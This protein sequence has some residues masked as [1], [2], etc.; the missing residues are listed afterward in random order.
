MQFNSQPPDDGL[1]R[2]TRVYGLVD[3]LEPAPPAEREQ[4]DIF[5]DCLDAGWADNI[6]LANPRYGF[7]QVSRAQ[8]SIVRFT[9]RYGSDPFGRQAR[10]GRW[11]ELVFAPDGPFEVEQY[12][13]INHEPIKRKVRSVR[14]L[15]T[16][17]SRVL[18]RLTSLDFV[19]DAS[20]KDLSALFVQPM[21]P[22]R[23]LAVY[24][25][26]QG[27][28]NA[29]C[30]IF[31]T[32]LVYFDFGGGTTN[33]LKT[34]PK[35]I[36]FCFGAQPPVVLSHWD[37]DHWASGTRDTN[38]LD[39]KWIA[40]RQRVG[41]NHAKFANDLASRGNL[42]LWPKNLN[43]LPTPFGNIVRCTGTGRND[44]GLA[45]YPRFF[46]A[47]GTQVEAL[48]PGDARYSTIPES[49][50]KAFDAVVATTTAEGCG[51][52]PCRVRMP[53]RLPV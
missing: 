29:I 16:A 51:T 1:Y 6:G 3:Q 4:F 9:S 49:T 8:S 17:K 18:S 13:S 38:S 48:L 24:D 36:R 7:E 46:T 5:F 34:Y 30:T 47:S 26:G 39:V 23:G 33:N 41:L 40:P 14:A 50:A 31:G 20:P 37:W 32:P 11:F 10:E 21:G 35:N 2:V 42:L 25:V 45:F 15:P 43:F 52:K 12:A 22:A 44:S 19:P 28:C 27:N 53:H